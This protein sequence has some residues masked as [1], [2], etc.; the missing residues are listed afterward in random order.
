[1]KADGGSFL[2]A[3][4][5]MVQ[6]GHALIVERAGEDPFGLNARF[7]EIKNGGTAQSCDPSLEMDY[8]A[9]KFDFDVIMSGTLDDEGLGIIRMRASDYFKKSPMVA[10]LHQLL[11]KA[12]K[13]YVS[14][15]RLTPDET[16]GFV[17]SPGKSARDIAII[18]HK[19]PNHTPGNACSLRDV[20]NID[21]GCEMQCGRS[22]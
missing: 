6:E 16:G 10:K 14:K 12:C 1:L 18:R 19:L 8:D 11:I 5:I 22:E 17:H 13:A 2:K 20:P 21:K 15:N 9:A 3:G 7:E 4:D